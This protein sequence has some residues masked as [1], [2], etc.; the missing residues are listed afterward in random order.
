MLTLNVVGEDGEVRPLEAIRREVLLIA[1]THYGGS[2]AATARR[3]RVSRATVYN[4][5][6]RLAERPAEG[7]PP[8]AVS[9][10]DHPAALFN[11][12]ADAAPLVSTVDVVNRP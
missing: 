6:E 8:D 4:M 12:A 5:L 7:R 9:Q 10:G 3:L 1:L 11:T 2:R